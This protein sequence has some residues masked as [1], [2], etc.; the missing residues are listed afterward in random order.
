MYNLEKGM[1]S[2]LFLVCPIVK[3]K[4]KIACRCHET[5]FLWTKMWK[6]RK[7][8]ISKPFA[9]NYLKLPENLQ[10]KSITSMTDID[11]ILLPSPSCVC[12][13]VYMCVRK[14]IWLEQ[15]E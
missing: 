13:C 11:K 10:Q 7:D 5:I 12:I 4:G 9:R 14:T 15:T 8:H 6:Y 1:N 2:E 3:Y